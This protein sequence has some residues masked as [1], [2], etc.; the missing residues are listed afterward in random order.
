[1]KTILLC[2]R[3][4]VHSAPPTSLVCS[5]RGCTCFC[6]WLAQ[7]KKGVRS[8]TG[9]SETDPRF[10][11]HAGG[12]SAGGAADSCASA[13]RHSSSSATAQVR[14]RNAHKL[15]LMPAQ[16]KATTRNTVYWYTILSEQLKLSGCRHVYHPGPLSPLCL[17]LSSTTYALHNLVR[18]EE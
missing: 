4:P 14:E 8:S 18:T 15:V 7:A 3:R 10:R 13:V 6:L 5:N 12:S 17:V 11:F 9:C 2:I 1:M 16:Y